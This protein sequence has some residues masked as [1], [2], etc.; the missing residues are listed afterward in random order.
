M[1]HLEK[2]PPRVLQGPAFPGDD[3]NDAFLVM[4]GNVVVGVSRW[5]ERDASRL[6]GIAARTHISLVFL[7]REQGWPGSLFFSVLST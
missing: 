2:G 6:S 1:R 7:V 4:F 3:T 5:L